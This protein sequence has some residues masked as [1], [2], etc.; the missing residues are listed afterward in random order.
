LASTISK[1][2]WSNLDKKGVTSGL[3][4]VLKSGDSCLGGGP[5]V[6]TMELPCEPSAGIGTDLIVKNDL[7][8]SCDVPGYVFTLHTSCSC[9]G[10]CGAKIGGGWRFILFFIVGTIV[11]ISL[12]CTYNRKKYDTAFGMESFPHKAFWL[13][14]PEL[15]KDGF[16]F[17]S[18]KLKEL[19]NRLNKTKTEV[20]T[21]E[22]HET[23][24]C[25]NDN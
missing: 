18:K 1:P 5:R 13:E 2:T 10:G 7:G 15:V 20:G 16:K 14:L 19:R 4:Y 24:I 25:D 23:F 11:Y 22:E 17:T 6:I 3:K 8:A 21:H 9:P 12:G